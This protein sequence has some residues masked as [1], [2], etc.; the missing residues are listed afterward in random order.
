[1]IRHGFKKLMSEWLLQLS[2][3]NSLGQILN[4]FLG[5]SH[6]PFHIG[7]LMPRFAGLEVVSRPQ[8]H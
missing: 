3:R 7:I 1:M 8:Q 4:S 6:L 5:F 2:Q